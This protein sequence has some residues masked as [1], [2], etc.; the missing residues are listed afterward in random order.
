M[1]ISSFTEDTEHY[2]PP[3]GGWKRELEEQIEL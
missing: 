2:S 1:T 3:Y